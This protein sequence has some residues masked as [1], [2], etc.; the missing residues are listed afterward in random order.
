MIECESRRTVR[1][2]RGLLQCMR[3]KTGETMKIEVI[4]TGS[5]EYEATMMTKREVR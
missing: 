5:N 2:S 3:R 4:E 1:T